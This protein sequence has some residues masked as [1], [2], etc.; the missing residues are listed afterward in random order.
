MIVIYLLILIAII[1]YYVTRPTPNRKQDY[2]VAK[3]GD[4][5]RISPLVSRINDLSNKTFCFN[6]ENV[7]AKDYEIF[8]VDGESMSNCGIHTGEGVLV[9]RLFNKQEINS[10]TIVIYEINPN[11]YVHDHPE[12]DKP[13]YGF[14]IRQFLGYADLNDSNDI[15]YDKIKNIDKD[16]NNAPF[17]N[18]LFTKL[19]KARKYFNNQIVTISITYKDGIK[20]YSVHSFAELYGFVKYIIPETYMKNK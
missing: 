1:I 14:K 13:Q 9:S 16:L 3:A 20:D 8:I 7:N 2:R 18:L 5:K 17:K 15:I 10:G 11:R 12:A 4:V 19:D 6:G